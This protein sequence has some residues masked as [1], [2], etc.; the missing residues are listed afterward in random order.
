MKVVLLL[1]MVLQMAWQVLILNSWG[2]SNAAIGS[3]L[4][5]IG[6]GFTYSDFTWQSATAT[7]N[8]VNKGQLL[9]MQTRSL[10]CFN[11]RSESKS[12]WWNRNGYRYFDRFRSI[13]GSAYIQ[14]A[15]GNSFFD[16]TVHGSGTFKIGDS[17]TITGTK[18]YPNEQVQISP[19]SAVTNNGLATPSNL[20]RLL[21]E[22]ANHPG[23]LVQIVN[24][25]FPKPGAIILV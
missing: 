6:A 16:K 22:M 4:Q 3:S 12:R 21:W 5:P 14:D 9:V 10:L 24:T 11:S 15:T 7:Y 13:A 18:K 1:P 20:K 2:E 23:E 25:T 19:V 17:P 8:A